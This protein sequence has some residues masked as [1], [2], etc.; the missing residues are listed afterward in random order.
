[1]FDCNAVAVE[2]VAALGD[3]IW[4]SILVH[5]RLHLVQILFPLLFY[6]IFTDL[7]YSG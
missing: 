6:F 3:V 7:D 5:P 4:H 2:V 1:M